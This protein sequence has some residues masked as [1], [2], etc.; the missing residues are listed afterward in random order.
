MCQWEI[1]RYQRR[2]Q[3]PI[4]NVIQKHYWEIN[5]GD[6][7]SIS[8]EIFSSMNILCKFYAIFVVVIVVTVAVGW[9][10][11]GEECTATPEEDVIY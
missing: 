9:I 2:I 8:I 1:G 7:L 10:D 3:I 5:T 4:K 6:V 11:G